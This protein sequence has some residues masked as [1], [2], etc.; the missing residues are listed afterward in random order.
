MKQWLTLVCMLTM[1]TVGCGCASLNARHNANY[2]REPRVYPATRTRLPRAELPS[3]IALKPSGIFFSVEYHPEACCL[4]P[5]GIVVYSAY[6]IVEKTVAL[7]TDTL[8]LPYDELQIRRREQRLAWWSDLVSSTNPIP[9]V[10][11]LR[12]RY[13]PEQCDPLLQRYLEQERPTQR[14]ELIR[15][16]IH[17][18]TGLDHIA[19]CRAL[20]DELAVALMRRAEECQDA[21]R[22]ELRQRLR[23][24]HAHRDYNRQTYDQWGHIDALQ[25]LRAR[26][27]ENLACNP[28]TT[29]GTLERIW[30]VY[31][32]AVREKR[33]T[34]DEADLEILNQIQSRIPVA[35]IRSPRCMPA[36]AARLP[37]SDYERASNIMTPAA[38]LVALVHS[39]I[40]LAPVVLRSPAITTNTQ[41]EICALIGEKAPAQPDAQRNRELYRAVAGCPLAPAETLDMIAAR[42]ETDLAIRT[43]LA[44][45]RGISP[46]GVRELFLQGLYWPGLQA[47]ACRQDATD[48]LLASVVYECNTILAPPDAFSETERTGFETARSMARA[49]LLSRG[50]VSLAGIPVNRQYSGL[51]KVCIAAIPDGSISNVVPLAWNCQFILH[52]IGEQVKGDIEGWQL[53]RPGRWQLIGHVGADGLRG[54]FR[55][56]KNIA[57]DGTSPSREWEDLYLSLDATGHMGTGTVVEVIGPAE[58]RHYSITIQR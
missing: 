51:W 46:A 48:E 19:A 28:S 27:L 52:Q 34:N 50:Y 2:L 17:L 41:R 8:C 16:L 35:I 20:D 15:V 3:P 38:M 5:V 43:L 53:R 18:G 49:T 6:W 12:D 31:E 26:V 30:G 44:A 10:A 13:Q 36:M 37:M 32:R 23:Q 42:P 33:A 21:V 29:T 1:V 4:L 54:V 22:G 58:S 55:S 56:E 24:W 9:P 39:N 45:H 14:R 47:V 11:A 25:S 57:A 40:M 7:T